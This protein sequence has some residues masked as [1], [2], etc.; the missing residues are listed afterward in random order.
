MAHLNSS[1]FRMLFDFF[2][3]R[4]YFFCYHLLP[5]FFSSFSKQTQPISSFSFELCAAAHTRTG[6]FLLLLGSRSY[7][8]DDGEGSQL[9]CSLSISLS[10][11]SPVRRFLCLC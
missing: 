8:D 2:F 3:I 1:L 5:I 4:F 10:I 7:D 6:L 11:A 9:K